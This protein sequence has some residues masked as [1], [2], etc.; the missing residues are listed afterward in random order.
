[1]NALGGFVGGAIAALLIATPTGRQIA[2][3]IGQR[4]REQVNKQL[5]PPQN[6]S[7]TD[8]GTEAKDKGHE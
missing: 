3:Q 1:M 7:G 6:A 2:D 4:L 8:N 5:F